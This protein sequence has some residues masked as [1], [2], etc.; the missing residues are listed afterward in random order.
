M[1]RAGLTYSSPFAQLALALNLNWL[2]FLLY[3]DAFVSASGTGAAYIASSARMIYDFQRNGTLP[4]SLDRFIPSSAV[5]IPLN[6]QDVFSSPKCA[7]ADRS[8][9]IDGV[10]ETCSISTKVMRVTN[11]DFIVGG[12]DFLAA[13]CHILLIMLVM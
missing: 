1:K 12:Q 4:P 9:E 5:L 8:I 7:L 2:A 6:V 10:S 11:N 13:E 3:A